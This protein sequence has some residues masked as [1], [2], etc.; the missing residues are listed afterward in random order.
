MSFG[1]AIFWAVLAGCIYLWVRSARKERARKEA[2]RLR[3]AAA[4][5]F[6]LT[7]IANGCRQT[8]NDYA[9][10]ALDLTKRFIKASYDSPVEIV[11]RFS[12]HGHFAAA[13]F[14]KVAKDELP[15]LE[16]QRREDKREVERQARES[17]AIAA[18]AAAAYAANSAAERRH[19]ESLQEA[20]DQED[21]ACRERE[22]ERSREAHSRW[23]EDNT[24]RFY[25]LL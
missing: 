25:G 5:D 11:E 23:I 4:S 17:A 18:A 8:S 10:L 3:N 12:R 20:R 1:W 6:I 19:R 15:Q 16:A 21:R 9:V 13:A 2:E 22:A 24:I 7:Q 14:L